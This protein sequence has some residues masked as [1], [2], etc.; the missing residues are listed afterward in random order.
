MKSSESN[1]FYLG[2]NNAAATSIK[3]S[4]AAITVYSQFI[5]SFFNVLQKHDYSLCFRV[6]ILMY[7]KIIQLPIDKS[8]RNSLRNYLLSNRPLN[9]TSHIDES[10]MKESIQYVYDATCELFGPVKADEAL[11]IAIRETQHLP[12]AVFFHPRELL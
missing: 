1:V 8:I 5:L 12:E 6:K 3:D 4:E 7:D 11:S 10:V 9:L 2:D